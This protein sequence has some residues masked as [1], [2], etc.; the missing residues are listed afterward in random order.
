LRRKQWKGA[1]CCQL[2]KEEESV[3]HLLF[4]CPLATYIWAVVRDGLNWKVIP[5][6]KNFSEDFLFERGD[7]RNRSLLFMFGAICWTLWLNRNDYIFKNK[8]I[9]SPR[10]LIYKLIS[11]LQHWMIATWGDREAL[12]RLAE[13]IRNG[14]ERDRMK[15]FR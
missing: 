7:K 6:A 4:Q 2:C 13:A 1:S 10:A 12:E 15:V 11:F 14:G 5:S 9:S 3:D 8:V